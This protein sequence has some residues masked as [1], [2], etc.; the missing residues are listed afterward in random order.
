[1][2][3]ERKRKGHI[4]TLDT[5]MVASDKGQERTMACAKHVFPDVWE[6]LLGH[7]HDP[8]GPVTQ[9]EWMMNGLPPW[10]DNFRS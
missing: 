5:T 3:Q 9:T 2:T 8:K 4:F 10:V 7:S 1:M 6:G